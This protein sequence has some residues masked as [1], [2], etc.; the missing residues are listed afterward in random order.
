MSMSQIL[1]IYIPIL[2]IVYCLSEIQIYLEDVYFAK[3]DNSTRKEGLSERWCL[4]WDLDDKGPTIKG[5]AR[6]EL[7][8]DRTEVKSRKEQWFKKTHLLQLEYRL[9]E[10]V[11][12]WHEMSR[13]SR[14]ADQIWQAAPADLQGLPSFKTEE[15]VQGQQ[16]RH[17]RLNRW[18]PIAE[19]R[20]LEWH[21]CVCAER[22]GR[23]W[24]QSWRCG[25]G[26]VGVRKEV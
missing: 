10:E 19:A 6:K 12:P 14:W 2:S 7:Q 25:R 18:G 5:W 11:T 21:P 8:A 20:V 4:N 1:D 13:E 9:K 16:Q 3:S 22:P 23:T 24:W 15:R 17:Q 26:R